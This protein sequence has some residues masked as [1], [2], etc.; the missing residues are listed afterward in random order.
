MPA[1]GSGTRR[2]RG[3]RLGQS[4]RVP[5]GVER[6]V[7]GLPRALSDGCGPGRE[8][9]G[10]PAAQ[11]RRSENS[12]AARYRSTQGPI[13]CEFRVS[14]RSSSPLGWSLATERRR[15]AELKWSFKRLEELMCIKRAGRRAAAADACMRFPAR[16][17][18]QRNRIRTGRLY[19]QPVK[20]GALWAGRG[21]DDRRCG[22]GGAGR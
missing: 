16:K 19:P 15:W 2:G 4:V 5:G 8:C 22:T 11:L 17:R 18:T 12:R 6:P 7:A 13:R 1:P 9:S 10:L 14:R 21:E 20:P 3:H